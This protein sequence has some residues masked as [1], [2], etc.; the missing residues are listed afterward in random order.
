MLIYQKIEKK[1]HFCL[2]L[3][4][5]VV[6]FM[7]IGLLTLDALFDVHLDTRRYQAWSP[8]VVVHQHSPLKS[9]RLSSLLPN[10]RSVSC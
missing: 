10:I 1:N 7:V 4:S 5:V 9:I 8:L 2:D 6:V 3:S